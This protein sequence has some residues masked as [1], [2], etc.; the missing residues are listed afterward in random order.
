MIE[1]FLHRPSRDFVVTQYFGED[2]ACV[3]T[4]P[5]TNPQ[6]VYKET[7]ASCPGGYK[8]VYSQMNGHNGLDLRFARWQPVYALHD[9]IVQEVETEVA[10]G[11]GVGIVTD[12]QYY[13]EESGKKEYFKT[14]YWHLIALNVHKGEHVTTGTLIGWADSTGYSTGDHLHLELKPVEV[15]KDTDSK[16]VTIRNVLQ[17]N[18]YFGAIDPLKYMSDIYVLEIKDIVS[19]LK[20]V[21]EKLAQLA[22]AVADWLRYKKT[23]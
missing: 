3:A 18:G 23:M 9:G 13:C 2:K 15:F 7:A 14:R 4:D 19:A 21:Q 22:D 11:L 20:V 8:S 6:Y 1:Q 5:S 10:R 17:N 16:I 12:K